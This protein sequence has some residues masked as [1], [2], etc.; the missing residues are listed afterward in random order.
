MT[1]TPGFFPTSSAGTLDLSLS[2][3]QAPAKRSSSFEA[4]K[5][6]KAAGEF[7]SIL[8]ES[9]WK[10]MKDTFSNQD[11]EENFDPT[12]RSFDEWGIQA[13]ARAVGNSGGLGIKNLILKHLE[14]MV[15]GAVGGAIRGI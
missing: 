2:A 11:D 5:L 1:Q 6:R 10:S 15:P 9:M 3:P 12:L 8:L 7:E 14:P 13:M 4:A